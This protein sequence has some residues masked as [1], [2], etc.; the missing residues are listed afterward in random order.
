VEEISLECGRCCALYGHFLVQLFVCN[1]KEVCEFLVYI[2]AF[3]QVHQ[4]HGKPIGNDR[5]IVR[6]IVL[7][8]EYLLCALIQTTIFSTNSFLLV[9]HN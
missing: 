6:L 1:G 2:P 8:H 3:Y 5:A 4:L 7:I 9:I